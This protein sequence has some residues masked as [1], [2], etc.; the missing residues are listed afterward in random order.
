MYDWAIPPVGLR[1]EMH[2]IARVVGMGSDVVMRAYEK[3]VEGDSCQCF[4]GFTVSKGISCNPHPFRLLKS[5]RCHIGNVPLGIRTANGRWI[6]WR[7]ILE[8][9]IVEREAQ[10]EH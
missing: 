9:N 8:L 1:V 3:I 2:G 5:V 7:L 6:N 10:V 4:I